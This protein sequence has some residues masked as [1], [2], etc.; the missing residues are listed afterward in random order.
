MSGS[1]LSSFSGAREGSQ[2]KMAGGGGATLSLRAALSAKADGAT[3]PTLL[4]FLQHV[5]A[6]ATS[7]QDHL[8]PNLDLV[9][10]AFGQ[11]L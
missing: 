7:S 2:L 11:V 6:L 8:G 3:T 9:S 10:L 4:H 5:D 1:T